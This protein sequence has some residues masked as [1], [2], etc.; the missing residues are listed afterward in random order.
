MGGDFGQGFTKEYASASAPG[1]IHAPE[2]DDAG[3]GTGLS[4]DAVNYNCMGSPIV[5]GE[6]V[7]G[8]FKTD[9]IGMFSSHVNSDL[10][11]IPTNHGVMDRKSD[12]DSEDRIP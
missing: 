6:N 11:H 7:T 9:G 5:N 3:A 2:I 4:Y 1:G 12:T 10:K 8:V